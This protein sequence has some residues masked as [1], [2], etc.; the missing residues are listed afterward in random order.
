MSEIPA[1][2]ESDR[3]LLI[4]AQQ[5]GGLAKLG[6]YVRL[7]GPGWLQSALTLGG[8][9]LASSLYLGVVAGVSMLWLQPVA[10]ILGIIM[11]SAIGYVT[12]STGDRPFRAITQKINPVLGWAW[13]LASMAANMVWALP[14]YSLLYGVTE[15]NLLP[16][17]FIDGGPLEGEAGKWIVSLL[18]LAV[19][20]IIVWSYGSGGWGVKV[21]EAVLK[22][23]VALIVLCFVAVAVRIFISADGITWREVLA[24]F[25]PNLR[26]LGQPAPGLQTMIAAL[27]SEQIRQYWTD[28]IVHQQREVMISAAAT[29]VGINMT[30]LLPYS[31]LAKKWTREFRGLSMFDLSTGMFIPF[32]LATSCVTIAAANQF[33]GRLPAAVEVVQGQ[34]VVPPKSQASHQKALDA[35]PQEFGPVSLAE[36]KLAAAQLKQ[37]AGSLANS[38]EKL[39]N[40]RLLAHYIFGFG[41]AAM[42]LS[43]ISILMLISG[44][45]VC[46]VLNVPPTGWVHR[47]GC[48]AAGTG[49]LWPI[50][51]SGKAKFWLAIVTSNFGMVLLPIAYLTF[52]LMMNSK[53]LLGDD[54]PTGL[55]RVLVNLVM[56]L[57]TGAAMFA[58]GWVVWNKT[59]W[60]GAGGIAALV[61]LVVVAHLVKD[62]TQVPA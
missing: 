15:Q 61:V 32:V 27:P 31:M 21:Y 25:V 1:R 57:A 11:L 54:L 52:L 39:F 46:E 43:T 30:F 33:H 4:Q 59:G 49:I 56:G 37:D 44:F 38:L 6:S 9:S 8:G 35:R 41:V 42:A 28:L 51:W 2:V 16:G 3:Q 50:L 29:A 53:T 18:V 13:L 12:L 62:R 24:G 36:Q 20:T 23:V 47:I 34:L 26:Q 48:L 45:V 58:S 22:V 40:N 5:K 60:Y 10:M 7:S 19:S 14:Q 17:L 55:N